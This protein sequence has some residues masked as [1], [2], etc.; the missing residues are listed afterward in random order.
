MSET[1]AAEGPDEKLMAQAR[2]GDI[3]AIRQLAD[4][5][6]ARN[7]PADNEHWP[8]SDYEVAFQLETYALELHERTF[9]ARK[10]RRLLALLPR[11]PELFGSTRTATRNDLRRHADTHGLPVQIFG[12]TFGIV[13]ES[14]APVP[15]FGEG[16]TDAEAKCYML[17]VPTDGQHEDATRAALAAFFRRA[18]HR[19]TPMEIVFRNTPMSACGSEALFVLGLCEV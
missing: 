6:R 17:I 7:L 4:W 9:Q 8:D 15:I 1:N 5:F 13:N 3:S 16:I 12:M 19:L 18:F 11:E 10:L 2:G 14:P